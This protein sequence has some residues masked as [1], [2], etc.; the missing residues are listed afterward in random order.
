[1]TKDKKKTSRMNG[2]MNFSYEDVNQ[3]DGRNTAAEDLLFEA[4]ATAGFHGKEGEDYYPRTAQETTTME[5][6]L[7][8]A[9]AAVDDRSDTE[10]L[11]LMADTRDV[12]NWSKK[13]HWTFAWW[14]IICVAIMGGYIWYQSGDDVKHIEQAKKMTDEQVQEQLSRRIEG[15]KETVGYYQK[16]LAVDTLSKEVRTRYEKNLESSQE[17]LA[18]AEKMS[19]KEYRE[20][21]I[22][23]EETQLWTMR[24]HSLWCF[25]WIIIYVL[26]CRPRGYMITKRRREDKVARGA[27]KVL[28]GIAGALVGAAGAMQVTTTITKWS[29]GS[30]TKDDDAILVYAIK[31]GLIVGAVLL[32]IFA[33]RVII[34]IAAILGLIRNYDWKT[35]SKDPKTLFEEIK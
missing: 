21:L 16:Q 4:W 25:A 31:I 3:S 10:L 6:L 2:D 12:I 17:Q 13:R 7:D 5:N 22:D 15:S 24:K 29:D 30:K 27:K 18:E 14:I 34:M 23:R 20:E 8:K 35:I 9:E 11:D 1:M 26:A 33:A 28:F 32:V 19:V